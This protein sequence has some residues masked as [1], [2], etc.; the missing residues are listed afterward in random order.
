MTDQPAASDRDLIL[1]QRA[2]QLCVAVYKCTARFPRD[3]I[4]GLTPQLRR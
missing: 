4:Y 2:V 3:E 1:W